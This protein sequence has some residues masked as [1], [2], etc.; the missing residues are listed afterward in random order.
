[1]S[2]VSGAVH[3][4]P[5]W[6]VKYRTDRKQRTRLLPVAGEAAEPVT[7]VA[8]Q[9]VQPTHQIQTPGWKECPEERPG[10]RPGR[11][12]FCSVLVSPARAQPSPASS[13]CAPR[14]LP[15]R[16][17]P[18]WH[19]PP[20]QGSFC[21]ARHVVSPAWLSRASCR[22]AGGCP[23]LCCPVAG[24]QAPS[25]YTPVRCQASGSQVHPLSD[26]ENS[27]QNKPPETRHGA[28]VSAETK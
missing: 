22:L 20:G 27:S 23:S 24:S 21:C 25:C 7:G 18:G 19:P 11:R 15:C 16:R 26:P 17:T 10:E 28:M 6:E 4:T 5:A 3:A 14:L 1:M 8:G 12:P 2:H 9:A 13:P